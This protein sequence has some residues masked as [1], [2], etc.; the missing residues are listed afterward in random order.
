LT[1][2]IDVNV[3]YSVSPRVIT[4]DAP[5]TGIIIQDIVDTLRDSEEAFA[6]GLSFEKL[7][8]ASGK[9]ELGGGVLV[10]LTGSLQ[11]ALLAFEGR[12]TPASIGVVESVD[13]VFNGHMGFVDSSAS[14][15]SNDIKRGSLLINFTDKSVAD[16]QL[17]VSETEI[18]TKTLVNG[19]AN[20]YTIGDDYYIFNIVQ[21]TVQGGNLVAVDEGGVALSSPILPT[22]F[23]QVLLTSSSSATLQEQADIEY[24][25]Y[26][27]GVTV[28][29][30]SIYSGTDFPIGTPRA[31][32]NNIQ[33][34][35]E[36]ATSRG[37]RNIYLRTSITLGA[38]VDLAEFNIIGESQSRTTITIEAAA[39]V[40]DC[41]YREAKI[42]GILDGNSSIENCEIGPLE[43]VKGII[44][45]SV[46]TSGD[47]VLGGSEAAQFIDC[48]SGVPGGGTPVIDMGGSG[49]A[50]AIRGYNGGITLKNKTGTDSASIDMASGSVTIENTVVAGTVVLRGIATWAN[51]EGY[52]GGANIINEL[53][54]GNL[55]QALDSTVYDAQVRVNTL[56]GVSGTTFPIGTTKAT[57]SNLVDARAIADGLNISRFYLETSITLP[58]IDFTNRHFY[59]VSAA[60]TVVTIPTGANV[61]NTSF[62]DVILNGDIGGSVVIERANVLSLLAFNGR[63]INVAIGGGA[64][65][66]LSGNVISFIFD[67]WSAATGENYPIIDFGGSGNGLVMRNYSG[68]IKIRNK[69]GP[70]E[71]SISL[72]GG[73]I[74]IEN[75]VTAGRIVLRGTGTWGDEASYTG[76]A[77]IVNELVD[78]VFIQ[79]LSRTAYDNAVKVDVGSTHSGT[80]YPAG[81]GKAP[82]NNIQDAVLIATELGFDTIELL[83]DITLDT[84][85]SVVSFN[86][87]GQS[88]ARTAITINTGADVTDCTYSDAT[89]TGILDGQST[90]ARCEIGVL[91]ILNGI[92]RSCSLSSSVITLG[93]DNP[94]AFIDCFS[95]VPGAST[96][97]I[98]MGGS[99]QA[100]TMRNYNGGITIRNKNG[101]DDVSIDM[102]SGQII[103][104]DTVTAGTIVMRGIAA[105]ANRETYTGGANVINQLIDGNL[106]QALDV[107]VYNSRVAVNGIAGIAGTNFP[108]G[109]SKQPSSN[110]TDALFIAEK[111][112]IPNIFLET[113]NSIPA[114][115]DFSNIQ[116]TGLSAAATVLSVPAGS[117]VDT[118]TYRELILAG[119]FSGQ[120][121]VERCQ[122]LDIFGFN[123]AMVNVGLFPGYTITL[124][125]GLPTYIL[126]SWSASTGGAFPVI[127]MGESG[128]I[129]TMRNFSGGVALINKTGPEPVSISLVGGEIIIDDTVANG[130]ITLRGT[131]TW[132]NEAAYTGGADVV[133][134]LVDGVFIQEL[135][136]TVYGGEVRLDVVN[137]SAGT[138]YPIGT[139]ELN[140]NNIY[141]ALT[142]CSERGFTRIHVRGD[143][144]L[145]NDV[146]VSGFTFLADNIRSGV[147]TVVSGA[148]TTGAV[149]KNLTL[150]GGMTGS[151]AVYGSLIKTISGFAGD[152]YEC[153]IEGEI[154]LS[155]AL[156]YN[157]FIECYGAALSPLSARPS[158]DMGGDKHIVFHAY[159]GVLDVKNMTSPTGVLLIGLIG[160]GVSFDATVTAGN[161]FM[162]GI[163]GIDNSLAAPA[164]VFNT[165]AL[166]GYDTIGTA[167]W[168]ALL[169]EH[170]GIGS[171]GEAL[172]VNGTK[173]DEIH[174]LHGLDTGNPLVVSATERSVGVDVVQDITDDGNGTVT[175]TRQ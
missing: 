11:N 14:F 54:D 127:D 19:V 75:T 59:G 50:L 1:A 89:V 85:D 98:D 13:P 144:T 30:G 83:S 140:S 68:G 120:A 22:A 169:D 84:G 168:D 97:T 101:N 25:S 80:S 142:I 65:V 41:E 159:K 9:D 136:Q 106:V 103:L 149:F 111:L 93:G 91:S 29:V 66:E 126:D 135:S 153:G 128:Q 143:L 86:I 51:R 165:L 157:R 139:A 121:T 46:L 33:D 17:V 48:V 31:P 125:G 57:S 60:S 95:G 156:T 147:V 10:G 161:V 49:Q 55:I 64:V 53:I 24:A 171:T 104:D 7:L 38:G 160:G 58:E 56:I 113:S 148:I 82:V 20:N 155:A 26:D 175:V 8:N 42:T 2:R 44:K 100:L 70:E 116:F 27:G 112:I 154:S 162:T 21:V 72:V 96:P 138:E 110:L 166:V 137:G 43:F 71:V 173:V 47:I 123:G 107:S 172:G 92:V 130:T 150:E 132:A 152:M 141:D 87:V 122:V 146:D 78:G 119:Y 88:S 34:A 61:D 117:L 131:G 90:L 6:E 129:L 36:I 77:D 74:R 3:D 79:D 134:E 109:T 99:G 118:T 28:S 4:V 164:V 115:V 170:L 108:I 39:N 167:V 94:T 76:G 5:S 37:F 81:T 69:T 40:L 158:I 102:S 12:T 62:H 151:I 16:V 174:K 105:W 73:E 133:N 18:V 35:V 145:P 32:V 124:G 23:T 114:A 163:G 45:R 63:M 52:V 15:I 67:S